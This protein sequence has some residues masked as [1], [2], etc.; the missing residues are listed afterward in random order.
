MGPIKLMKHIKQFTEGSSAKGL[1]RSTI[2][3]IDYYNQMINK[4][5]YGKNGYFHPNKVTGMKINYENG[6]RRFVKKYLLVKPVGR[7]RKTEVG[8]LVSFLAT[9]FSKHT[10]EPITLNRDEDPPS[11]FHLFCEP[12]MKDLKIFDIRGWLKKHMKSR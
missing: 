6:H 1:Y 8:M 7:P 12:I 3:A 2:D 11:S 9:S 10:G 5:I 4:G